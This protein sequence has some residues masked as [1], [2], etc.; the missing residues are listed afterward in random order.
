MTIT[1]VGPL[2]D[3]RLRCS[4]CTYELDIPDSYSET[5]ERQSDDGRTYVR[6][7]ITRSDGE[8][9][10]PES[11]LKSFGLDESLAATPGTIIVTKERVSTPPQVVQQGGELSEEAL[12]A[13]EKLLQSGAK[14]GD[15][16]LVVRRKED[17]EEGGDSTSFATKVY[18]W[19]SLAV[20]IVASVL[21][22]QKGFLVAIGA[23]GLA[24]AWRAWRNSE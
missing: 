23:L 16:V 8:F 20:A 14:P 5:E 22:G 6:R 11:F 4:Y 17:N 7:T 2:Q 3:K 10:L 15:H 13:V 9:K 19:A 12:A 18:A 1:V 24:W 21:F